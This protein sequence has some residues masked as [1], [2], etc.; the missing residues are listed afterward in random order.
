MRAIVGRTCGRSSSRVTA[1]YPWGAVAAP[2][3]VDAP[4]GRSVGVGTADVVLGSVGLELDDVAAR[5][6][7]LDRRLAARG[8]VGGGG[9]RRDPVDLAASGQPI[10]H[11]AELVGIEADTE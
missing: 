8:R 1:A 9:E 4:A 3:P 2:P 7:D 5:V 10:H 6:G 11:C